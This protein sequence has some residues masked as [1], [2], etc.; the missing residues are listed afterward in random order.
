MELKK[1]IK[2]E[3]LSEK[4]DSCKLADNK[5]VDAEKIKIE[6]EEEKPTE[7]KQKR[8]FVYLHP[9]LFYGKFWQHFYYFLVPECNSTLI[10][11]PASLI[12]HWEA[13]IKNRFVLSN[14][15]GF[16]KH[17]YDK[18]CAADVNVDCWQF[19]YTTEMDER[20][21]QADFQSLMLWSL[22][23]ILVNVNLGGTMV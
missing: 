3:E 8:N 16:L 23:M 6:N 5:Q 17:L 22:R 20:R 2:V 18:A 19:I 14:W 1:T 13:E 7:N 4:L 10:I 11:A 9:N 15:R 21:I 12:Y